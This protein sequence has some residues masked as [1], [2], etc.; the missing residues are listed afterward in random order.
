MSPGTGNRQPMAVRAK[1]GTV[2]VAY[3]MALRI[4]GDLFEGREC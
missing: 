1:R 4:Q 3:G 2:W